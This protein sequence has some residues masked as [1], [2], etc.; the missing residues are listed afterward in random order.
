MIQG[1]FGGV[2]FYVW[3]FDLVVIVEGG[4]DLLVNVVF[5]YW[6]VIVDYY[7]FLWFWNCIGKVFDLILIEEDFCWVFIGEIYGY[8]LG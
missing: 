1:F 3:E 8:F 6:F 2:C 7:Y 4:L 5:F